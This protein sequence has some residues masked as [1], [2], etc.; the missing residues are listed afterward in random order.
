MRCMAEEPAVRMWTTLGELRS[1]MRLRCYII[2]INA[3][4]EIE[5]QKTPHVSNYV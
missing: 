4:S 2:Y 3:M 1:Y 5:L